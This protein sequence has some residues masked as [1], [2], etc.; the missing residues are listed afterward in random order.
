MRLIGQGMFTRPRESNRSQ[1]FAR[2]REAVAETGAPGLLRGTGTSEDV[3]DPPGPAKSPVDPS[4]PTGEPRGVSQCPDCK[5][6]AVTADGPCARCGSTGVVGEPLAKTALQESQ[7]QLIALRPTFAGRPRR[8]RESAASPDA[9]ASPIYEVEILTEGLGNEKDRVFYTAQALRESASSGV[10]TGMQAYA[11]HPGKDEEYN[12]PERDIRELVGYYRGFKFKESGSEGK[13]CVA[14]E[15]V[16]NQGTGVQWFVDLLESA[17]AAKGDG[18][19]LC[20]ISIDGGGIVELGEIDGQYTNICRQITEAPSADVVTKPAAGGNIV[21]R[22]RESV[23]R[24]RLPHPQ[25]TPMK[26]AD[27]KTKL[28]AEHTKLRESVSK[29]TADGA[30][31]EQVKE[32][33]TG[34]GE[35]QK[36]IEALTTADV[37]REVEFREAASAG[38]AAAVTVK[39]RE[40]EQKITTLET[41]NGELK[42]KTGS[43]E[44][45]MFAAQ[46]LREAEI[47]A[48]QAKL[49]FDDL[50]KLPTLDAMNS[51]IATRKAYEEQL[52]ERFRESVGIGVGVE[53]AGARIPT[54]AL[55][56]GGNAD[57]LE[58][59]GIPTL[60][61]E[62][63]AAAA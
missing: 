2:F 10:F 62:P 51:H 39:L 20:G 17:I 14:A 27:L 43:L 38:D 55:T 34:L 30:T 47:P 9:P 50:S 52:F 16:V 4:V 32:A 42:D 61:P 12:R 58:A 22:L 26:I 33:L 28:A 63:A 31:D 11:N 1:R 35:A 29:L 56:G 36:G 23:Q 53:G 18:V 57:N 49:W 13:P 40:A 5:G 44:R 48:D 7:T 59:L 8:I 37:E 6:M 3:T 25:E 15:L 45:G 21:R 41:E 24:T 54:P 46:A 19:Q 60:K